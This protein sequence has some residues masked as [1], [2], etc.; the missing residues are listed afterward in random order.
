M[1]NIHQINTDEGLMMVCNHPSPFFCCNMCKP[2]GPSDVRNWWSPE[3]G[4]LRGGDKPKMCHDYYCGW[5]EHP[6][7]S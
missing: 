1:C 3:K 5:A 4:C 6:Y 7:N 2:L